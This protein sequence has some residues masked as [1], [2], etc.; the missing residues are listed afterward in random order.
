MLRPK[1]SFK[2]V[3]LPASRRVTMQMFSVRGQFQ[4]NPLFRHKNGD[5]FTG[6]T[7]VHIDQDQEKVLVEKLTEGRGGAFFY[8]SQDRCSLYQIRWFCF[9]VDLFFVVQSLW[10]LRNVASY[11]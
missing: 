11:T 4:S 5:C 1:P 2:S 3:T 6:R 10:Q 9:G 8:Y 7:N